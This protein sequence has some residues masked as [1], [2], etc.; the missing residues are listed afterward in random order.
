M[1]S[2]NELKSLMGDSALKNRTAVACIVAAE[3]IRNEDAGTANHAN[4][5]IWAKQAFANPVGAAS[6]MLM[7]M[8]AANKDLDASV[9]QGASDAAIQTKVDAAVDVFADGS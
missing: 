2:Y 7:A 9:I 5:L 6:E 1:A 4:R 3:A 8:L